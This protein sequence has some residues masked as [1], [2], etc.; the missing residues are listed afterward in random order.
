MD[1][2]RKEM[3]KVSETD[4]FSME[5]LKDLMSRREY[6]AVDRMV[7]NLVTEYSAPARPP[8]SDRPRCTAVTRKGEPCKAPAVWLP[9][10]TQPRN[11]KCRVHGGLSTG[12]NTEDGRRAIAESN[13]RRAEQIRAHRENNASDDPMHAG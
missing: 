12:P 4:R 9:G 6:A 1:A 5:H 10:E 11:G 8:R 7:R 13:R 2:V 3:C